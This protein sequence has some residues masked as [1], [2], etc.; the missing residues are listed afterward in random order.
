MRTKLKEFVLNSSSDIHDVISISES[1][2]NE[3]INDGEIV[4]EH[5]NLF[6]KDRNTNTSNKKSG[7]GVFIAVKKVWNSE[8]LPVLF[9]DIEQVFVKLK[10]GHNIIIIGCVYIPPNA[11]WENY[12]KHIMDVNEIINKYKTCKIILT[13]DYNLPTISSS[14]LD[15]VQDSDRRI[16]FENM[17]IN[18]FYSLGLS[19]HNFIYNFN[20]KLL[21]LCLSNTDISVKKYPSVL[22][23]D[24]HHPSLNIS[25]NLQTV[26]QI[27]NNLYYSFHNGDYGGLNNYLL[28]INWIQIYALNSLND[29]LKTFY[30]ILHEGIE[31]FVPKYPR[32]SPKFPVWFNA[33][34]RKLTIRKRK[35][36]R[37]Y[38]ANCNNVNY[39]SFCRLRRL[40]KQLSTECYERYINKVESDIDKN[41]QE[42]WKFVNNKK[43][44]SSS[45]PPTMNWVNRTE[46]E[47]LGISSMFADFFKK[48]YDIT[49]E[50][51]LEEEQQDN[52]FLDRDMSLL[53][54]FGDANL[55]KFE[56]TYDKVLEGLLS[57]D[58]RKNSGPDEVPNIVLRQCAVGLCDPVTH[59]FTASHE[60]G[61]FSEMWKTSYI[62]PIHKSGP[63]S[64]ITN[65]RPIAK[66]SSLPKLLEKLTLPTITEAFKNII[67]DRQHGFVKGRSTITNL[68]TYIDGIVS[69]LD[70]GMEVHTVYTD[71]SKAFDTVNPTIL[72]R[73]LFEYG[74][75]NKALAWFSSYLTGRSL[76]VIIN[77][78]KSPKFAPE[79]RGFRHF[80]A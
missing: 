54:E 61:V 37:R 7:G 53:H 27:D 75:R 12:N 51:N 65:Y 11:L 22:P 62:S 19:Q 31:L 16:A 78:T 17:V 69:A 72:I 40:C 13:G 2:L 32:R 59:L 55:E 38:K 44:S 47:D 43:K 5:Y 26:T 4:G 48:T 39:N 57:L 15:L 28:S 74:V 76:Q 14:Y 29:K 46:I 42:F 67:I 33:E 3:S 20:N 56:I 68:F 8:V 21:D 41:P 18:E 79:E 63:R 49:R 71:L 58:T 70:T 45:I 73:K 35:V 23:E 1:W 30:R 50:L 80:I 10:I 52:E 24:K 25:L 6:R 60:S 9:D 66:Q 64:D 34:L 77:S 36:H